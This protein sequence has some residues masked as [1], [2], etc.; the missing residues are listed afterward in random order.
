MI[1]QF[2]CDVTRFTSD[3]VPL[4]VVTTFKATKIQLI[5]CISSIPSPV[6]SSFACS[7]STQTVPCYYDCVSRSLYIYLLARS[8]NELASRPHCYSTML[9][10]YYTEHKPRLCRLQFSLQPLDRQLKRQISNS[11]IF[12]FTMEVNRI[13]YGPESYFELR[14]G[15]F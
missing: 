13:L 1:S 9:K 15:F 4:N 2:V 3:H 5:K 10:L 14:Y 8:F 7:W 6:A 11:V 12:F